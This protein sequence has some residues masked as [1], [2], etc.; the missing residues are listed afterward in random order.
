MPAKV[1]RVAVLP[2]T[3]GRRDLTFD[4][5]LEALQPVLLTELTKREAFEVDFVSPDQLGDWTGK[6]AWT[7]EEKLPQNFF[8]VL[9][10]AS[11]C[12]AVLFCR[13]TEFRPY[14]PMAVGWHMTLVTVG[15]PKI[16]WASDRVFD[17]GDAGTGNAA[18]RYYHAHIW[19][20]G[21]LADPSSILY[22]PRRFGQYTASAVLE[23]LPQR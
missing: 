3:A 21:A 23:S 15:E 16:L 19:P 7:A 17:A 5:G 11:G 22:S 18:R 13:L 2:M 4:A 20:T 8:D 14:A 9:R 10:E 6:R 1:R 12:D